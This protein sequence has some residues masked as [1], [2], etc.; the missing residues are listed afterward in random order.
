MMNVQPMQYPALPFTAAPCPPAAQ[1][2]SRA[3]VAEA[4][5]SLP[6]YQDRVFRLCLGYL[7]NA[8]DAR[9]LTQETF[10]R[11]IAHLERDDPE[12]MQAWL[13]RIARNGC[14]DQLRRTRVRGPA[15]P[16]QEHSLVSWRTPEDLAG[17]AEQIRIVRRAVAALPRRLRDVLVMREYG[18]LR[19][20]EIGQALGI[21]QAAVRSRLHRA[22]LAVLRRFHEAERA[23]DPSGR[24]A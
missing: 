3:E 1:R 9:D 18:E 13:L 6:S 24:V 23:A 4:L 20:G 16:L 10:A 19:H 21:S 22:R 5:R 14:L 15:L 8:A 17:E 7:G 2:R 11:A 12:S